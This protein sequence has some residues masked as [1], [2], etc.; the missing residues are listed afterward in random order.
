MQKCKNFSF[1]I[2]FGN[3]NYTNVLA[4]AYISRNSQSDKKFKT[5]QNYVNMSVVA[6]I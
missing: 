1:F 6:Y 5:N 2:Y 3:W 4:G